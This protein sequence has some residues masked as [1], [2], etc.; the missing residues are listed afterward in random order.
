MDG[1]EIC[2]NDDG[3]D[4]QIENTELATHS[5]SKEENLQ[6]DEDIELNKE[7]DALNTES[8]SSV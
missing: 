1:Q 8:T 2:N 3:E 5:K 6:D 7:I 4:D